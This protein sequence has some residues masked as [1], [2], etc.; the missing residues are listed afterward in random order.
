[1]GLFDDPFDL[2]QFQDSGGLLGRLVSA[3][4]Q[5][6]LSP[7]GA[8]IDRQN[9]ASGDSQPAVSADTGNSQVAASEPDIGAR[10]GAGLQSWA[11]TPAGSPFAALANGISGFNNA[12]NASLIGPPAPAS[13]QTPDLGGSLGAAFQSWAQTPVGNPLAALANGI[14]GFNTGQTSIPSAR[15][16]PARTPAQA[17]DNS[18]GANATIQNLPVAPVGNAAL[19]VPARRLSILRRWPQ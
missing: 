8:G 12:A 18:N 13:T 19:A 17:P 2:G 3:L 6:N 4:P 5:L 10:L 11:Q 9:P 15:L 14:N 16:T 7:S 1:M